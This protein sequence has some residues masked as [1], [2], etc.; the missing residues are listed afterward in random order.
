MENDFISFSG[1]SNVGPRQTVNEDYILFDDHS[2]GEDAAFFSVADG[3]GSKESLF[4]PAAIVSNQ[5]LKYLVRFY[6]KDRDL[7][8]SKTRLLIEEAA[9][10]ANDVLC[11]FKLGDE[12]SRLNFATS[13]TCAFLQRGGKLTFAHAGNTRLYLIRDGRT[14]Q[15][16]KD[17]TVGQKLVDNQAISAEA[18]YTAIERLQLY[19]E[20]GMMSDPYIQVAEIQ[21]KPNDVVVVTSDGIHYNYSGEEAFF[22][23][24]VSTGSIEEAAKAMVDTA[25]E[26]KTYP[27]NISV[28]V[29]W[30]LGS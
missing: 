24:L 25:L 20:F 9:L 18:Y 27:D 2:F 23:I 1:Q 11:S 17:H 12:A 16:T 13:A 21:L 8:L 19:N 3:A 14:L 28:D 4:R 29:A 22:N 6:Q 5:I 10:S 26:L 15:L 7:A 30:Y